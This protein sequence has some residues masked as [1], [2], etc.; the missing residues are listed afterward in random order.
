MNS[1]VA[2]RAN[3]GKVRCAVLL[4]VSSA[5]V[6]ADI[7]TTTQTLSATISPYGKLSLPVSVT[8]TSSG[9]NFASYGGSFTVSYWARTSTGGSGSIVLQAT[10]EFSPASGPTAG[11]V[12]YT[13]SGATLG[14]GCSGTQTIQTAGQTPVVTLPG[15]VCTGG[16]GTCSSQ[17][18]NTV[19]LQLTLPNKPQYKTGAY[20]AQLTLTISTL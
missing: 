12:T 4:L 17:D 18:P 20:S 19:Q 2:G 15:G 5:E 11:T 8:L 10:S 14:T 7:Q 3:G 9:T 6:S 13:C 1:R 16:G